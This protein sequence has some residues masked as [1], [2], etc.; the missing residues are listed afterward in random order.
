M[1]GDPPSTW[2]SLQERVTDDLVTELTTNSDGGA[3]GTPLFRLTEAKK[4]SL[5]EVPDLGGH[6]PHPQ[7]F[8]KSVN[9]IPTRGQIHTTKGEGTVCSNGFYADN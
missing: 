7:I 5:T 6:V 3:G 8:F 2:D 4:T 1:T 9:S